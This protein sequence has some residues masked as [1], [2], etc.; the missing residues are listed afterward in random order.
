MRVDINGLGEAPELTTMGGKSGRQA[1][2]ALKASSR[3]QYETRF[4][5]N[6][7]LGRVKSAVNKHPVLS[8]NSEK[9]QGEALKSQEKLTNVSSAKSIRVLRAIKRMSVD[10]VPFH[11]AKK[12]VHELKKKEE[13][14]RE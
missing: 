1:T 10:P 8:D 12:P 2:E 6:D 14:S 5:Q 11:E 7:R 13:E 3:R 9:H 4:A